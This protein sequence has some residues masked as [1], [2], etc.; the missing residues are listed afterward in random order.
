VDSEH[1][2]HLFDRRYPVCGRFGVAV[3]DTRNQTCSV[4]AA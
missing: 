2:Q 1:E 4:Q 3:V